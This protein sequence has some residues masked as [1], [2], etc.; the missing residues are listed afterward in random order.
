MKIETSELEEKKTDCHACDTKIQ[1]INDVLYIVGG[2]WKISIIASL[3]Y[4]NKRY[5]ELLDEVK[6]ISGKMLSRELKE[7]ETNKLVKRTVLDIKPIGVEYSLTDH[8][9]SVK[10][11]IDVIAAWGIEHREKLLN[12]AI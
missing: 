6:G 10:P 7:L 5:S 4:G 8:G 9:H 3:G 12:N 1:A 2:K 11:I